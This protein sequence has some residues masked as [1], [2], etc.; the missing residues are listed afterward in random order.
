MII[1]NN[2]NNYNKLIIIMDLMSRRI[3]YMVA[4]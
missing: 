1:T 4:L 3:E 2:Y